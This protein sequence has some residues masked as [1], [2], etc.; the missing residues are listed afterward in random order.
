M[1]PFLTRIVRP[2]TAATI[3]TAKT[4]EI[5]GD[6]ARLDA[7]SALVRLGSRPEGLTDD[8]AVERLEQYGQNVVATEEHKTALR[9]LAV[10]LV[11]PLNVMLLLLAII[12][13]FFL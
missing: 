2:Q 12:N 1:I 10:L 6:V 4:S 13:F 8:E 11:N 9:Q 3:Q 5:Y 7:D